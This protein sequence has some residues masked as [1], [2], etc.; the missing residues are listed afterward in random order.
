MMTSAKL[1]QMLESINDQLFLI[2]ET[3]STSQVKPGY[4][5]SY[6][7]GSINFINQAISSISNAQNELGRYRF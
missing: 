1:F 2:K 4:D 3:I 7:Q 6:R 5:K